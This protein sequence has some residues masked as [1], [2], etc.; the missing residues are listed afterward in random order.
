MMYIA[1]VFAQLE[2]EVIA[3]RIRDNM[4]E[5]AKT[6]RWL[7]GEAPTG[8]KIQSVENFEVVDVYEKNEDNIIEKKKRKACKLV[9][10]EEY[11]ELARLIYDKYLELKSLSKLFKYLYINDIKSRNGAFF[12]VPRLKTILTNPT[13]AINSQEAVQ[14][15]E[16]KK[17]HV[18]T[19]ND[20]EKYDGKHALIAYGKTDSEKNTKPME[21]WI[22]AIGLHT[23]I[24]EGT[25]WVR[26]QDLLEKN[27]D[28]RYRRGNESEALLSGII[29]CKECG[30]CMRPKYS[31]VLGKNKKK[32]YY[33][34]CEQKER[35]R[36]IKC[37]GENVVGN[38]ADKLVIEQ[39]QQIFV[40]NSE[41]YK[42]L[43][44]M[45]VSTTNTN[46]DEELQE[47]Q[48]EHK[49]NTDEINSLVNKLKYIDLSVIEYVNKELKELKE[50][51]LSIEK[52]I[53][54]IEKD[55]II[56][57][58]ENIQEKKGIELVLDII[59]NCSQVF[60]SLDKKFK[61][62][63]LKILIEDIKASKN[64]LEINFLNTR[65]EKSTKQ[66][67]TDIIGNK[68]PIDKHGNF[69]EELRD[70][71]NAEESDELKKV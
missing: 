31:G 11:V 5:L 52:K 46:K 26:V 24:I 21:E 45:I 64:E 61:K 68:E 32:R 7:G 16:S 57:Y 54:N 1:S 62:D 23:G 34:T 9:E 65:L 42:E 49:K 20:E 3:E 44:S 48:K 36:G 59:N 25:K 27:T 55:S 35:S 53:A 38:L 70:Y 12:S 58:D 22:V 33:Y 47:L 28:K 30:S 4:I 37:K 15:F 63:I 71:N 2:R 18:Y 40:P 17:I 19:N 67:F 66:I 14:Y 50:K 60:E 43:K 29:K 8:Y 41:I 39:L 56:A 51:N 6:G 13:Y 69:L 10:D